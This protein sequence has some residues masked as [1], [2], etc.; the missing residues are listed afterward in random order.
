M[1]K[2]TP[3]TCPLTK[4]TPDRVDVANLAEA[5]LHSFII[6]MGYPEYSRRGGM[7][8]IRTSTPRCLV[9]P[10]RDGHVD[11]LRLTHREPLPDVRSPY[12]LLR[13]SSTLAT[14]IVRY[15]SGWVTLAYSGYGGC[16]CATSTPAATRSVLDAYTQ[17]LIYLRAGPLVFPAKVQSLRITTRGPVVTQLVASVDAALVDACFGIKPRASLPMP[18]PRPSAQ[19]AADLM[20]DD[21]GGEGSAPPNQAEQLHATMGR[22]VDIADRSGIATLGTTGNRC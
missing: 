6:D 7:M 10:G 5:M 16:R 9:G 17:H 15:G 20:G 21:A 1:D 2:W 18:P 19:S 13:R 4:A 14:N 11:R 8:E 3:L 12:M 22:V